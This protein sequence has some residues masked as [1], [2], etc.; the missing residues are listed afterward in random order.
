MSLSDEQRDELLVIKEQLR[1]TVDD[2]A[3]HAEGIGIALNAPDP[4]KCR[5]LCAKFDAAMDSH[6]QCAGYKKSA[7][8]SRRRIGHSGL[9][10]SGF[11]SYG[12]PPTVLANVGLGEH[13]T[14][15][16]WSLPRKSRQYA[17]TLAEYVRRFRDQPLPYSQMRRP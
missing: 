4:K 11:S 17:K 10:P 3:R 13:R 8:P 5:E 14:E 1:Q 16:T 7:P 15:P 12:L 2:M 9:P 6:Q